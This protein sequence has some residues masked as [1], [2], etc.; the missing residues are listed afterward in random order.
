MKERALAFESEIL[1]NYFAE[2]TRLSEA[3][4]GRQASKPAA[5][6]QTEKG[7]EVGLAFLCSLLLRDQS[8]ELWHCTGPGIA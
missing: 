4:Q 3:R 6:K 2:V 1:Q 5:G 8:S 7:R